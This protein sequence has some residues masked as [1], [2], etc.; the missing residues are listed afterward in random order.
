[1]SRVDYDGGIYDSLGY[2]FDNPN[3]D[4]KP[5][6]ANT[7]NHLNTMPTVIT[8]WQ[9][10]DIATGNVGGYFKNPVSDYANTISNHAN[11]IHTIVTVA[12]GLTSNVT[13]V[14]NLISAITVTCRDITGYTYNSAAEESPPNYVF[15]EGEHGKYITHTMRLSGVRKYEDDVIVDP[16]AVV[17][18]PY[19]KTASAYGKSAMYITNQTD[20]VTDTSPILGSF[21]S[22]MVGPQLQELGNTIQPHAATINSSIVYTESEPDANGNTYTIA[23]TTLSFVE[24][25][26]IYNDV[27]NCKTM[28]VTRRT[29]DENFFTK[30]KILVENYQETNQ[31][32]SLGESQG[33]L[34]RNLIGSDK[35]IERIGN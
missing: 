26:Q 17:V 18:K 13:G 4:I 7:Q 2:N 16:D 28:L 14:S 12:G 1:M 20:D 32:N 21:T 33:Y 29:H 15:V 34:V 35:L 9:A 11:A 3:G 10:N 8:T 19:Y 25:N 5:L 31:F 22:L 27:A 6:T 24:M 23:T 30:L